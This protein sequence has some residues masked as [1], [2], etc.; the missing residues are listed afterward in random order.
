MKGQTYRHSFVYS[1]ASFEPEQAGKLSSFIATRNLENRVFLKR[2]RDAHIVSYETTVLEDATGMAL[3]PVLV[4]VIYGKDWQGFI[5]L[6]LQFHESFPSKK[7][8]PMQLPAN[9][10]LNEPSH[11]TDEEC[12]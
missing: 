7:M 6:L 4:V 3:T 12:P 1:K 9:H 2:K 5:D 10:Y 11:Y 8:K